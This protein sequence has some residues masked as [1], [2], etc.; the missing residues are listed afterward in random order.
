META[1][2]WSKYNVQMYFF[3]L[4]KVHNQDA[5]NDILQNTFL[6]IHQNIH[7]LKQ[8]DKAKSWAFQIVRN[9]IHDYFNKSNKTI[10][11]LNPSPVDQPESYSDF[12]CF[13]R[14]LENLPE[15]YKSVMTMVYIKG[16]KQKDAASELG[17]S[18]ANVKARIRRAKSVLIK[19]FNEC[20]KYE[21]NLEGKLV[22]E[23]DCSLCN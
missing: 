5:T 18:L 17:I 16:M 8:Q 6:K 21:L 11:D 2:I 10:Q 22:G 12:C 20:C 3:I 7:Q 4:K 19:K 23:S 1:T 15:E 9:E 14:F 13:D